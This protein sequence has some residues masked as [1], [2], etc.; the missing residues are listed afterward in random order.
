MDSVIWQIILQIALIAL[1]AFFTSAEMAVVSVN[2]NKLA[3]LA[4]EGNKR[5]ARLQKLVSRPARFMSTIQVAI[6]FSGFLSSAFAAKNFFLPLVRKLTEWGV[7]I[8]DAAMDGISIVIIT[9]VL[10]YFTLVFGEL[11]P[12]RVAMKNPEKVA[13]GLSG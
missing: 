5:A 7:N 9:L 13:L 4:S 2:D 6:T 3:K 12:K 1:N 10:S 11:V 8:P